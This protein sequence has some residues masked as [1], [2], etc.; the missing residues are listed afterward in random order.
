MY[1]Y[2]LSVDISADEAW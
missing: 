2:L 1:D